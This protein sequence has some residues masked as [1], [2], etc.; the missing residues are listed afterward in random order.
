MLFYA[1]LTVN[2]MDAD[3]IPKQNHNNNTKDNT[4]LPLQKETDCLLPIP[5]SHK[6]VTLTAHIQR[7]NRD[8]PDKHLK[9][10]GLNTEA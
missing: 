6:A 4:D 2:Y 7:Q 1:E 5:D 3:I 10:D 9:H 8:S